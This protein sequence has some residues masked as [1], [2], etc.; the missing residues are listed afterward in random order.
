MFVGNAAEV[1]ALKSALAKAKEEARASKAAAYKVAADVQAEKVARRQYEA[2]V[3]E[4]E[5]ALQDAANKCES[6]EE[7]DKAQV[8]ELTKAL[9]EA[10][11]PR[12]KSR[13]AREENKQA[14]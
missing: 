4:V 12:T 10:K 6:L 9:Q 2:R 7:S 3:T 8:A 11:E 14:E 13:A 1:E 5:Q